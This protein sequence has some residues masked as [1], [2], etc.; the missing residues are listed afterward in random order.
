MGSLGQNV[1]NPATGTT[2][3]NYEIYTE[4]ALEIRLYSISGQL[5]QTL[6][7]GTLDKG[8]Y[9]TK[10]SLANLPVGMYHYALFVNGERTDTK[11]M[12]VN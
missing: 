3:I 8:N 12:V 5:L 11:K 10:V 7:Q 1:P 6:P 4:G 9:Q 2:T